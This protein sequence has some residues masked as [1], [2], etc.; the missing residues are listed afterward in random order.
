M[1]LPCSVYPQEQ[2]TKLISK[3][4][5][6]KHSKLYSVIS[7]HWGSVTTYHLSASTLTTVSSIQQLRMKISLKLQSLGA[8]WVAKTKQNKKVIHFR[9]KTLR[10]VKKKSDGKK[11]LAALETKPDKKMSDEVE[12]LLGRSVR[13]DVW[14]CYPPG[15]NALSKTLRQHVNTSHWEQQKWWL[16]ATLAREPSVACV[17]WSRCV[18]GGLSFWLGGGLH[19]RTRRVSRRRRDKAEHCLPLYVRLL[20]ENK[21]KHLLS[22]PDRV[23][24]REKIIWWRG[25]WK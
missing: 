12:S 7:L 8:D 9:V 18:W 17:T 2:L 20:Q 5:P 16:G 21:I 10:A 25:G 11:N 14:S 24:E 22:Q 1:S 6:C 13:L 19:G 3:P 23:R 4:G 15:A